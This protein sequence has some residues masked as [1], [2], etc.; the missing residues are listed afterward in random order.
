MTKKSNN[1]IPSLTNFKCI[2]VFSTH[3]DFGHVGS[4]YG[5]L[6]NDANSCLWLNALWGSL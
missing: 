4:K 2:G 3:F 6:N 1:K 5:A